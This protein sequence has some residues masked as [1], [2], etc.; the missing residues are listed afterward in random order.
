LFFKKK[1]F[2]VY[3][4]DRSSFFNLS[5][6]RFVKKGLNIFFSNILELT[7]NITLILKCL[8]HRPKV[9]FVIKGL[10]IYPRV[11]KYITNRAVCVNW[12]LDDFNN[13]KN[14]N[15]NLIKTIKLYDLIISPKIE[16][17]DKY[18][19]QGAKRLFFLE[20]FYFEKYYYPSEF[21]NKYN[22]SF[23]GSWSKKRDKL[24]N[25]I[26]K[27][28]TV[29]VFGNS[30][31]IN[32]KN[33]TVIK[34]DE[35]K[36][37]KFREVVSQSKIN[38]NFLTEENNDT[39]NLRFFEVSAC[40]GLLLNE[41]SQRLEMILSKKS[42]TFYFKSIDEINFVIDEILKLDADKIRKIT[43]AASTK[44]KKHSFQNRCETIL[45]ELE[46]IMRKRVI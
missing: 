38:L 19:D 13:L 23:I 3:R 41:Y 11:L 9:F 39:S 18:K 5:N 1:S 33:K 14:S 44:I 4:L 21:Q 10:N 40:K 31:K 2:E 17:F 28:H 16:L 24:I 29:H 12:N 26:A 27:N 45:L 25:L 36:P 30:W 43:N 8:I 6:N 37:D 20:N 46:K 15:K 34:Q 35:I 42:E 22:I 32:N 7:L